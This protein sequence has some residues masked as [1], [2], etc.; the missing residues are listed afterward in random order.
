MERGAAACPDR[1]TRG[2]G[3]RRLSNQSIQHF[4][5]LAMRRDQP[6]LRFGLRQDDFYVRA[7]AVNMI[8]AKGIA[9]LRCSFP[10]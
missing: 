3:T 4:A 1:W 6:P 5:V 10:R 9:N 7:A 2:L 8:A